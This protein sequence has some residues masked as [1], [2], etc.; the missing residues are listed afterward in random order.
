MGWDSVSSALKQKEKSK[1]RAVVCSWGYIYPA[2]KFYVYLILNVLIFKLFKKNGE[3]GF[4]FYKRRMCS[5]SKA[6]T[7]HLFDPQIL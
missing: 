2:F 5:F 7:W 4:F 3:I 1:N 6:K